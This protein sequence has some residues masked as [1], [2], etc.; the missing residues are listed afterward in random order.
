MRLF[1]VESDGEFKEFVEVPFKVDHEESV[2]ET[3]LEANPEGILENGTLLI[4]GRQVSTNLGGF[5]DL[6][7]ADREG[8][9]VVIELKRDRTPRDTIA[10]ALEYTSFV[11]QLDITQ[12]EE[13]LASYTNDDA[14]R[15]AEYH[16]QYFDLDATEAVAFNKD[17][18]IVI[19]GQ[20]VTSEIR[21]TASFLR[22]KGIRVTCIEFS[23]FKTEEGKT[24]LTNEVVVGQE[25]DKPKQVT[26]GSLPKV[27]E[28]AFVESLD[29]N[30][31]HV[32]RRILEFAKTESLPIHWGTKGFSLNVDL[33]GNHV[34][35]C[36]CYPPSAVYKQSLYTAFVGA[37]GLFT[38][39]RITDDIAEELRSRANATAL[40]IPAGRELKC[41]IDRKF[42]AAEIDALL[43]WLDRI[44]QIVRNQ[45]LK[46]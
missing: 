46:E 9:I 18:R 15:L 6:L 45:G 27:S 2:L 32:F 35:I 38:K 4:M 11:E 30:G 23:F 13:I 20:K 41:L 21:Q 28:E 44:V 22:S 39:V 24:L 8:D 7:A 3:W 25:A 14:V 34:S 31:K 10:Q 29:E 16:R 12:L 33:M 40:F 5:I 1:G 37:G 19:V 36:Y 43:S 17:Q 26:S 42:S